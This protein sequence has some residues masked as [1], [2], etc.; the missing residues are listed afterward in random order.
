MILVKQS[1]I[2]YLATAT[3]F[4][5][6]VLPKV[7]FSQTIGISSTTQATTATSTKEACSCSDLGTNCNDEPCGPWPPPGLCNVN[8]WNVDFHPDCTTTTTTTKA[9][10]CNPLRTDCNGGPCGSGPPD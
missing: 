3:V 8:L 7:F 4:S 10:W 9:C 2:L 1:V 6:S 5:A